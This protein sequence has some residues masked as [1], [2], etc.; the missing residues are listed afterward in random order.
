MLII[1]NGSLRIAGNFKY[2]GIILVEQD[3]RVLAATGG[4]GKIEGSVVAFGTGSEVEDNVGGN[5]KIYHNR[6]SIVEAQ[7]RLSLQALGAAPKQ[8]GQRSTGWFEIVR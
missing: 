5:A 6:C 3:V 7:S 8:F 2:K 4:D 1:R